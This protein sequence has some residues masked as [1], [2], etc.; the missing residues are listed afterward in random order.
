M[1]W[2]RGERG[3]VERGAWLMGE[4]YAS[5]WQEKKGGNK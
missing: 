2:V 5:S 1:A 4:G 3:Y